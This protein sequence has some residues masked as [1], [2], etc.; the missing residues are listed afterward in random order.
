[1]VNE[2]IKAIEYQSGVAT[3]GS[4]A[5]AIPHIRGHVRCH[6]RARAR[7]RCPVQFQSDC[8]RIS[9]QILLNKEMS[10]PVCSEKNGRRGP[11]NMTGTM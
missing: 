9:P 4:V 6:S 5:Y 7:L 2:A 10:F 3:K 8:L 11:A 1:M